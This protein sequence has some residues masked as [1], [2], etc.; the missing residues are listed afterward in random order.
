MKFPGVLLDEMDSAGDVANFSNGSPCI[1][2][3][4]KVSPFKN[5]H[6]LGF[7]SMEFNLEQA[8]KFVNAKDG[9]LL[10]NTPAH[11]SELFIF[12]STQWLVRLDH[13][14]Q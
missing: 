12:H 13:P 8:S 4:C 6:Q 10:A 7:N 1:R 5:G 2:S 11:V 14:F 3:H 9:T